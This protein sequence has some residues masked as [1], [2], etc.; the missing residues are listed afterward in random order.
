MMGD[1]SC[2]GGAF[3][4]MGV[5]SCCGGCISCD[6]GSVMLWGCITCEPKK[7]TFSIFLKLLQFS[8]LF[9]FCFRNCSIPLL[10]FLK[11]YV[12]YI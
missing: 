2:C 11:L 1:Q 4:V 8:S 7:T 5:Q 6:G 3:L 9:S 12:P 10:V